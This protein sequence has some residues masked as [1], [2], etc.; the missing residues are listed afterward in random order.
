MTLRVLVTGGTG[1]VGKHLIRSLAAHDVEV[2][3]VVKKNHTN[4]DVS[5]PSVVRVIPTLDLFSESPSWWEDVCRGIDVVV[6]LA[7]YVEPGKYLESPLNLDCLIGSLNLA[8]G[9]VLAGV[10]RIV[11]I[12]TCFEYDLSSGFVSVATPLKPETPYAASKAALYLALSQWLPSESV[13]FAWCRLFYLYGEGEDQRRLVPYIRSQLEAGRVAE[14]SSGN[15]IRDF[16][17]V[18]EAASA[19][20]NIAMGHENGP[21]DICTGIPTTIRELATVIGEDYGRTDLL[22]FGSRPDDPFNPKC[23]VGIRPDCNS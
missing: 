23:V 14:L 10:R 8:K 15:Q 1:F 6:H 22:K 20:A 21:L 2:H 11:G 7:W 18:V 9:A 16:M 19:I 17:N 12:G 13:S 3:L 4:Y 5:F